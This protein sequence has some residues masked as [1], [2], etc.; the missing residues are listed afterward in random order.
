MLGTEIEHLLRLLDATDQRTHQLPAPEH[1]VCHVRCRM[2]IARH[3]EQAHCTITLEQLQIVIQI[4]RRGHR[5]QNEIHTA[6]VLLHFLVILRH[7]HFIGTQTPGIFGLARRS[8]KQHD[9]RTKSMR[10]LNGHMSKPA[11]A[12]NA[13]PVT[14]TDAPE[15]QR[16]IRGNTGA[17]QRRGSSRI[18]LVRDMQHEIL[19][20]HDLGRVTTVSHLAGM[21]IRTVVSQDGT[22]LAVLFQSFLTIRTGT[23]G[24]DH[25]A[26]RGQ[27]TG[28]KALDFIT[29]R[30]HAADDLVSRHD[31]VLGN[32]PLIAGKMD[33]GMT[34]TAIENI[35]LYIAG[36]RLAPFDG[37]RLEGFFS[38]MGAVSGG[39][40]QCF[41]LFQHG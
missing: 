23:T 40:Q 2:R 30:S 27:L 12:D 1:Q 22:I 20:D 6:G 13:D 31:R 18:E 32:T 11:E 21:R 24:I 19:I 33:I 10:Q 41:G 35:D 28:L 15:I 39:L 14:R 34:D 8:C 16:R 5:I 37:Q 29:Y 36:A 38:G 25:A 7:H 9:M 26:D 3:A 17:E 4:M